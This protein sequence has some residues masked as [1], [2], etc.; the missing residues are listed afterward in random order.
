MALGFGLFSFLPFALLVLLL[1]SR[2]QSLPAVWSSAYSLSYHSGIDATAQ[3]IQRLNHCLADVQLDS[4][5]KQRIIFIC[6]VLHVL[7]LFLWENLIVKRV[8][9]CQ[10]LFLYDILLAPVVKL[11]DVVVEVYLEGDFIVFL[12]LADLIALSEYIQQKHSQIL[13]IYYKT[14]IISF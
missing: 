14:L 12:L 11:G 2:D 3:I 9:W 8:A 4:Y 6:D 10:L 7:L 13:L 5:P 1:A